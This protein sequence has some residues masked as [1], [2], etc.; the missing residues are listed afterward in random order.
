MDDKILITFD[1]YI[2]H[3]KRFANEYS[4]YNEELN[5]ILYKEGDTNVEIMLGLVKF[6]KSIKKKWDD[7]NKIERYLAHRDYGYSRGKHHL[8]TDVKALFY[9]EYPT[10]I[11]NSDMENLTE[12]IQKLN[13]RLTRIEQFQANILDK[14]SVLVEIIDSK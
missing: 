1:D 9:K 7:C 4:G 3:M 12:D 14:I 6:Q 8:F 11:P 2:N 5:R 13:L 10:C